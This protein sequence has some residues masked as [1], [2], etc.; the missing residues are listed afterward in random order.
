MVVTAMV[1][2]HDWVPSPERFMKDHLQGLLARI[3]E[4]GS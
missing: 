3:K 2:M 1:A 4:Q